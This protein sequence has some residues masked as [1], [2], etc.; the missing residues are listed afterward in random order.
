M[1]WRWAPWAVALVALLAM[2]S[3]LGNGFAMDDVSIVEANAAVHDAAHWWHRFAE[4]YWPDTRGGGLYRPLAMVAYTGLWAVGGGSAAPFHAANVVLY[5]ALCLAMLRLSR[6]LLG[7]TAAVVAALLFAAH[8]VHVEAVANVVGMAELLAALPM[9][10]AVALYL[11]WRAR[12]DL[13]PRQVVALTALSAVACFG[14][15]NGVMLVL[16]L[17]AAE[18]IVIPA[19][20]GRGRR[21]VPLFAA[22]AVVAVT[23][24]SVRSSVLR[25][26]KGEFAHVVWVV[27]SG[28]TRHLTMLGV[29]L[30]WLRL[31]LWPARLAAEYTPPHVAVI[32]G[33]DWLLVPALLLVSGVVSVAALGRRRWPVPAFACAWLVITLLPVSNTLVAAGL[34]L[35]ERTL[36]MPSV[37]AMVLVGWVLERAL[38]H[39]REAATP[40]PLARPLAGVIV[41]LLVVG[42]TWRSATRSPVW[43]D[44]QTLFEQ[45]VRDVPDS[46]RAHYHLGA[47]YLD[48]DRLKE[49]ERELRQ[50]IALY[51]LDFEPGGYL[52]EAYRKHDLCIPALPL[53][54]KALAITPSAGLVRAGYVVCLMGGAQFDSARAVARRGMRPGWEAVSE[55]ERLIGVA[56]SLERTGTI[57]PR[58]E[59]EVR[60]GG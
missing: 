42:G 38:T 18:L 37:A 57:V 19:T 8:P 51:P 41:T 36:L 32:T 55:L 29:S 17:G 34:I 44:N 43:R 2:A 56:D 52:A 10:L 16:L 49:G 3:S 53:Y 9:V 7:E 39:A 45:T 14:K 33:W 5:V 11:E 25:G 20:N 12:G 50:A 27:N 28:A 58:T 26:M 4:S 24:V 23:Y 54:R 30:D 15:E 35:G 48:H 60:P 46:Y 47:W 59:R 1:R 31:L 13:T 6:A 21:L 40:S 22:L